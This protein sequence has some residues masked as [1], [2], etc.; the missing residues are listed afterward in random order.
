VNVDEAWATLTS[1][2]ST[3]VQ[4]RDVAL[5]LLLFF[6]RGGDSDFVDEFHIIAACEAVIRAEFA[7]IDKFPHK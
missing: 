4:R 6:A 7:F 3:P 5:E 1:A 2:D